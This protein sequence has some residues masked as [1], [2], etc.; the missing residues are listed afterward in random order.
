[1]LAVAVVKYNKKYLQRR[2]RE[3][4]HELVQRALLLTGDQRRRQRVKRQGS[5]ISQASNSLSS[6]FNVGQVRLLIRV[7]VRIKG[8][9][10]LSLI[11]PPPIK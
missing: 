1:M 4:T 6:N 10:L 9:K 11:S 8:F 2:E 7:I 3:W 5:E